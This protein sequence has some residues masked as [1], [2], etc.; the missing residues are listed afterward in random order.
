MKRGFNVLYLLPAKGQ[1]GHLQ[2]DG[3]SHFLQQAVVDDAVSRFLP[4]DG[5]CQLLPDVFPQELG[6]PDYQH[7]S[8]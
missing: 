1:S 3:L 6:L 7:R 5:V 2:V 4:D 8:L